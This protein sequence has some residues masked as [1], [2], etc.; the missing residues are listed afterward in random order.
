MRKNL[1]IRGPLVF[2]VNIQEYVNF[3]VKI[4]VDENRA[5]WSQCSLKNEFLNG[6]DVQI[7]SQYFLVSAVTLFVRALQISTF[8]YLL[9]CIFE[10]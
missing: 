4:V 3:S 5:K 8:I 7:F 1:I 2:S 9:N 10:N 6:F